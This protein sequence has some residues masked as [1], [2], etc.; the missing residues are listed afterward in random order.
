MCLYRQRK[1]SQKHFQ[2]E[3]AV[4]SDNTCDGVA[5]LGGFEPST[6]RFVA[7]HSIHWATGAFFVYFGILSQPIE[8][9]NT[10]LKEIS[11]NFFQK[12]QKVFRI[13]LL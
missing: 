2:K 8:V 11:K 3:N 5:R 9:V 1:N 12:K 10:F 6:Y 7:G 13:F 4:A